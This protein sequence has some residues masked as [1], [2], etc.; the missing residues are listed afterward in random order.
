[1]H[2]SSPSQR[3]RPRHEVQQTLD[4]LCSPHVLVPVYISARLIVYITMPENEEQI[5]PEAGINLV[6]LGGS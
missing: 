1:M 5:D 4:L 6:P 3:A 2:G